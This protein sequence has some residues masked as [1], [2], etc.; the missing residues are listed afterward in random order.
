V[1]FDRIALAVVD[2]PAAVSTWLNG[3]IPPTDVA[4]WAGQ[5]VEVLL[6]IYAK[7]ELRHRLNTVRAKQCVPTAGGQSGDGGSPV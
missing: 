2:R 4:A 7:L 3:G 5:S 1:G 6:R